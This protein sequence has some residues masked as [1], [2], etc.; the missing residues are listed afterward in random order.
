MNGLGGNDIFRFVI[1]SFT[2]LDSV[3]GGEGF[4][5]F[6]L[7]G[8]YSS[9]PLILPASLVNFEGMTLFNG[10]FDVQSR[11]E[12]VAAGILFIVDGTYND[13]PSEFVHFDGSAETD[14]R[15][16]LRGGAGND[17][18]IGGAGNDLLIGGAGSNALTGG[19]GT[20]TVDYSNAAGAVNVSLFN[21]LAFNNGY[22]GATD[23]LISVE[24]VIGS[25]FEDVLGGDGFAN[26]LDGGASADV[27]HGLNGDD[28]YIVDNASDF[29]SETSS[30]GGS[31]T[32]RSSA[33]YTLGANLENLILT[34]TGAING[35][36]NGLDNF[37]T[38]ND[39]NN[40]LDGGGGVDTMSGGLGDDT[41]VVDNA[42][43]VV[44]EAAGGRHDTVESCDS[45]HRCCQR[46][47][48][49]PDRRA[50]RSTG[51][52]TASPTSMIGNSAAN[53]LDGGVGADT[54]QGG[55]GN[56]TYIIDNAGD[57][58]TE[59]AGAGTDT[60]QSS[61]NHILGANFERLVLT[62]IGNLTGTGNGLANTL[63]GNSG[64]NALDGGGGGDTM[65]G[66]LGNDSYFV[67][68][69]LDVV[70]EAAGGG[71]D[72]VNSSISHGLAAEVEN[73]ILTGTGNDQRHRQCIW[74]TT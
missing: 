1:N 23:V 21:A 32:V 34:G 5:R 13:D 63:T 7:S 8:D 36:G 11:D 43:D 19:D 44:I 25:A 56:D 41:Y 58:V 39:G 4:D 71:T 70:T 2:P 24:N 62:G 57:V 73:L 37:L 22:G 74:P 6:D 35:T 48:P 29:A 30:T 16:E 66:G 42:G 14:G 69:G 17:T 12:N 53:T 38:G 52:A 50:T 9:S 49:D 15:F 20:D 65:A 55:L 27:M 47:E 72:T 59:A 46:R 10:S 61:L 64:A 26:V 68:N 31:D 67:D 3:D 33:N 54:M 60:V 45:L 28:T 51:P 18:L 40:R